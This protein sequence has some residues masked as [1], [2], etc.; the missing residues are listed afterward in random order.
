MRLDVSERKRGTYLGSHEVAAIMGCNPWLMVPDV[1]ARIALGA[2]GPKQT[3]AMTAGLIIEH[4]L[5]EHARQQLGVDAVWRDVFMADEEHGFMRG[6][7]DAV[8]YEGDWLIEVTTCNERTREHWGRSEIGSPSPLKA[9]QSQYLMMLS[10]CPRARILCLDKSSSE[11]LGYT[12]EADATQQATIRAT[13]IAFWQQHIEPKVP[14]S[15]ID[16]WGTPEH[17]DLI[18][19]GP[20]DGSKSEIQAGEEIA[21]YAAEYD[22]ARAVAKEAED[23]KGRARAQLHALLGDHTRAVWEGGSVALSAAGAVRE[24]ID[25]QAVAIELRDACRV[26]SADFAGLVKGHTAH[27]PGRARTLNV[28]IKGAGSGEA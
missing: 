28:R 18:W 12:L 24:E 14:P 6:S 16:G 1:Y 5:I 13:A 2:P 11:L 8:T 10:G 19:P 25:W 15:R 17:L 9:V 26:S 21:R 27:V 23:R 7:A 20:R 3:D 22:H 4:G